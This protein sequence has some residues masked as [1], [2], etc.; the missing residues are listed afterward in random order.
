MMR[1]L[2]HGDRGETT[3]VYLHGWPQS[4]DAFERVMRAGERVHSVALDLPGIGE[5][6]VKLSDGCKTTIADAVR[7]AIGVMKLERVVLAGHDIGGQVVFAYLTRY[8]DE[9]A[10]AVI[11]NVVIP[12]IPPWEEVIRNPHIWHFAFHSI[13]QLP[14]T[15][16]SG[17]ESAY[18]SYFFDNLVENRAAIDADARRTYASAY[19]RMDA[20]KTGFDWY[21]AFAEDATYNAGF[22]AKSPRISTPVLYVRGDHER[23]SIDEYVD[24][25]RGAGLTNL[26]SA[27]I[28]QCGH[29]SAEEAPEALWSAIGAFIA[30]P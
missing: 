3:I 23:G 9:L 14:E 10:G 11:M 20:L 15:L 5:S 12:G 21:R 18:F 27:V 28:P 17:N 26:Q 8:A 24:G 16:V 6:N 7:E 13:A 1:A 19:R 22:A 25:L 2:E 30:T 29:F 4:A